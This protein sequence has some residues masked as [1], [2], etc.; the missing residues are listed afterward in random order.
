MARVTRPGG[1]VAALEFDL[2]SAMV[3]HPDRQTTR[4]I[5]DSWAA[6]TSN[7]WMGR[8]LPR[9][10]RQAGLTDL[11]IKPQVVLVGRTMLRM[12][13]AMGQNVSLLLTI[14]FAR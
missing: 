9:M 4:R 14:L 7:G 8:Q 1:R 12:R 5:L 2:G 10:F 3:D 11:V 6:D 13:S